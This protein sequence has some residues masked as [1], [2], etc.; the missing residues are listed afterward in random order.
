[1]DKNTTLLK[2]SGE[3]H[4]HGYENQEGEYIDSMCPRDQPGDSTNTCCDNHAHFN[5]CGGAHRRCD[6]YFIF[7]LRPF[8]SR[9]VAYDCR[10]LYNNTKV[11]S[12]NENDAM[13]LQSCGA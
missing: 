3:T 13:S 11:T 2:I 4:V 9:R 5:N 6:S 12:V 7:C 10:T 8:G 1:M